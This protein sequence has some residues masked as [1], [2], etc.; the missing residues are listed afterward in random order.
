MRYRMITLPAF[1]ALLTLAGP[2]AAQTDFS[3]HGKVASGKTVEI[4]GISGDITAQAASGSE[5]EVTAHKH[6]RRSDPAEVQI[7]VVE[8]AEG[9]TICA[10]YPS[11]RGASA[12]D[13][14]RNGNRDL[15]DND[16]E[17]DFDVRVP[18]GVRFSGATV[19]GDVRA[20]GLKADAEGTTVNGGVEISTSGVARA[21]TVNGSIDVVMGRADWTDGLEFSTVNGGITVTLPAAVNAEV[22]ANTVNGSIDSDFPITVQGRMN[23]RSFHGTLG[24]GGR[25]LEFNTV[26]GSIRLRKAS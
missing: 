12:D 5:V 13:C 26:N 6:A 4:Q 18:A 16:V 15:R 21:T 2:A 1:G 19:N 8:D 9:V 22:K 24:S 17:V 7:K 25:D 14:R 23:P 20:T 11:R 3:W 10:I